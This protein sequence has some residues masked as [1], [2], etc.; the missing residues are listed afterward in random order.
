VKTTLI[1]GQYLEEKHTKD[2]LKT[3]SKFIGSLIKKDEDD[4]D[5]D[6]LIIMKDL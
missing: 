5:D 6:A 2:L 1:G 4:E 3:Y